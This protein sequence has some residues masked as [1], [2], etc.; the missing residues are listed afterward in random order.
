[1]VTVGV[2]GAE[3]PAPVGRPDS[4]RGAGYG[5]VLGWEGGCLGWVIEVGVERG[6]VG[7]WVE[8]D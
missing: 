4:R 5:V 6:G 7:E 8:I 3:A 1:M 2:D